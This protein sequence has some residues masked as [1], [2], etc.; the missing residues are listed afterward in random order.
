MSC[1]ATE[2]MFSRRLCQCAPRSNESHT[3]CSNPAY[4]TSGFCGSSRTTCTYWSARQAGDD[5]TPRRTRVVGGEHV[6]V[7]VAHDVP[8]DGDV[9]ALRVGARGSTVSMRPHSAMPDGVTLRQCV[10]PSVVNCT[11]PSS[12]PTQMRLGVDTRRRDVEDRVVKLRTRDVGVDRTAR[13]AL[14]AGIVA[15]KIGAGDGPVTP[16][17]GV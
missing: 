9:R 2:G 1:T 15:R 7:R 4:K 8:V 14:L 3:P 6:R 5:R 11:K 12:V 10:P 13:D 17:I 16:A